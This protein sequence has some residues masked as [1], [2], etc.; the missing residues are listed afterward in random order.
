MLRNYVMIRILSTKP[1]TSFVSQPPNFVQSAE[2]KKV[3]EKEGE[4]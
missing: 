4:P 1:V 2:L 3:Q